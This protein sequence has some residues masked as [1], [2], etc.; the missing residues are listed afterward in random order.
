MTVQF[1][2]VIPTAE[3]CHSVMEVEFTDETVL[4]LYTAHK[5]SLTP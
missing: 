3:V 4:S 1:A 2:E 5:R